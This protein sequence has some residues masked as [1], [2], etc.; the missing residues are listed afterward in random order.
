MLV[1]G[2]G[3]VFR[4]ISRLGIGSALISLFSITGG[5]LWQKKAAH[6]PVASMTI[7]Y[8]ESAVVQI[9]LVVI[10]GGWQI[11]W[12]SGFVLA[13]GWM[14]LVVSIGATLLLYVMLQHGSVVNVASVFYG[15]PPITAFLAY[16]FLREPLHIVMGLGMLC[17]VSGLIMVHRQPRHDNRGKHGS[18]SQ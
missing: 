16:V 17:V 1:V 11:H 4:D 8:T 6:H 15:V 10:F 14:V 2:N 13:L 12:T 3:L 18:L 5:T 9:L 7:Q